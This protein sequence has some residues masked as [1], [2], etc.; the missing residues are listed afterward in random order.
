MGIAKD[1]LGAVKSWITGPLDKASDFVTRTRRSSGPSPR[2]PSSPPKGVTNKVWDAM[3]GWVKGA[4]GWAGKAADWAVGGVKDAPARPETSLIGVSQGADIAGAV[5]DFLGLAKGGI[6]P[7][8]GTMKY[9]SGGYLPPGLTSVVNLTGKPEPVF[10]DQQ[11]G[12][13]TVDRDGSIH[14]EPHFHDSDLTAADVAGDMNFQ[15]RKMRRGGK[16]EGVG[17]P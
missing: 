14:Y 15:F 12:E 10:T 9:D 5:A 4:A 6:L 1:P 16:Y 8:N 3:P 13:M 7:Y 11:W 17:A 2:S